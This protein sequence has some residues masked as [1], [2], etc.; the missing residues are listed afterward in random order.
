M[1]AEDL[2]VEPLD[3]FATSIAKELDTYNPVIY[4]FG[5][6]GSGKSYFIIKLLNKVFDIFQ[7]S[8]TILFT[9][10]YGDKTG[11][12]PADRVTSLRSLKD[13]TIIKNLIIAMRQ[14]K[15]ELPPVYESTR[16][17]LVFDDVLN[18]LENS[19]VRTTFNEVLGELIFN[20]RHLNMSVILSSQVFNFY[21]NKRS[22]SNVDHI[23]LRSLPAE[24]MKTLRDTYFPELNLKDMRA[25]K[26]RL[27]DGYDLLHIDN[28]GNAK[29]IAQ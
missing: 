13:V 8:T 16:L 26:K 5:T 17:L 9:N 11:P 27:D 20:G 15:R 23:L 7:P 25:I 21:I 12:I 6:R 14:I 19:R 24:Y 2:K 28:H 18:G 3:S 4:L 10:T 29:F 22:R 1:L